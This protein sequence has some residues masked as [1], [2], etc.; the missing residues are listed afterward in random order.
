MVL[1]EYIIYYIVCSHEIITSLTAYERK[2]S[3]S[4]NTRILRLF[5]RRNI[6][7]SAL[8]LFSA[9]IFLYCMLFYIAC[10]RFEGLFF[11]L[12]FN[13]FCP[14]DVLF[15]KNFFTERDRCAPNA[16]RDQRSGR[17]KSPTRILICT[18]IRSVC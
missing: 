5:F 9:R 2:A 4:I 11:A 7:S 16:Q 14:R 1:M 15:D 3:L 10:L 18:A 6:R 17:S 12:Y 13:S 8:Q